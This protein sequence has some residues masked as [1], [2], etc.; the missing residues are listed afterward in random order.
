MFILNH[1]APDVLFNDHVIIAYAFIVRDYFH[2]SKVI[3]EFQAVNVQFVLLEHIF[4][5]F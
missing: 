4:D 5:E 3:S 2:G 1:N